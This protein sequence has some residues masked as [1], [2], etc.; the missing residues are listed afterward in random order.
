[1]SLLKCG[2]YGSGAQNMDFNIAM[3]IMLQ[4]SQPIDSCISLLNLHDKLDKGLRVGIAHYNIHIGGQ[5][6]SGKVENYMGVKN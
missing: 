1:V 5:F 2:G 3:I 6:R 4:L